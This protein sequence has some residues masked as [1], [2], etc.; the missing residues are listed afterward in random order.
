[1]VP[2]VL[3]DDCDPSITYTGSWS[4]Q[5]QVDP[6][7]K[8]FNGKVHK[9]TAPGS[10]LS[11]LF[12][13]TRIFLYGTFAQPLT[14][15]PAFRVTVDN[16][17]PVAFNS[18]GD[19]RPTEA[20]TPVWSHVPIFHMGHLPD[21]EHNISLVVDS[22]SETHPFYFDFITVSTS[23]QRGTM[24]VDDDDDLIVYSGNW[25]RRTIDEEYLTSSH[26][27]I[28]VGSNA[29]FRFNGTSIQVYGTIEDGV[30]QAL[31]FTLDASK[32]TTLPS[33]L[34]SSLPRHSILYQARDLLSGQHQL[35]ITYL[36][37]SSSV[38]LDYWVYNAST[39]EATDSQEP[40]VAHS[41]DKGSTSNKRRIGAIIGG[42]VGGILFLLLLA[43]IILFLVYRR[44]QQ[45]Q[46]THAVSE[47]FTI[48]PS[49]VDPPPTSPHV[50]S[51]SK[52]K[53]KARQSPSGMA[54]TS[55]VVTPTQEGSTVLHQ[56]EYLTLVY[57]MIHR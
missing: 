35:T 8:E 6:T 7:S 52:G 28:T 19:I 37:T 29:T 12:R 48:E 46:P 50:A 3:V 43:A 17:E 40:D 2:K 26:Q 54:S 16:N 22:A 31:E 32:N 53:G 44:R 55:S 36:N 41:P 14:G 45:T 42:V 1:M 56:T 11:Y 25:T 5:G 38:Y 23:H 4:V 33:P 24:V 13:G 27:P 15:A 39:G 34:N 51:I 30:S 49:P 57:P 9:T 18:S 20:D 21:E 47:P 10:S